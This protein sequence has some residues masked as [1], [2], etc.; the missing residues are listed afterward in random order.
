MAAPITH[1]VLAEKIFDEDLSLFDRKEFLLGTLFPDIRYL[2]TIDHDKTHFNNLKITDLAGGNSFLAGAKFHSIV[3]DAR[4]LYEDIK[5]SKIVH[6]FYE[7][8]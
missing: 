7:N 2:K 4:G 5:Y 6:D 8:Y 3:D 1:L